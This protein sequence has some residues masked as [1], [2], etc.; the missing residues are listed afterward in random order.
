MNFILFW[1]E[2]PENFMPVPRDEFQTIPVCFG[3]SSLFH[4]GYFFLN[5]QFTLQSNSKEIKEKEK[6]RRVERFKR[7]LR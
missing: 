3:H 6:M 2:W 7:G 1:L 4:A 5:P